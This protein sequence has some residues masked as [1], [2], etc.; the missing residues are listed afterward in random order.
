ML[1]E[2]T[3]TRETET[4]KG[5]PKQ[6]CERYIYDAMLVSECEVKCLEEYPECEVIGVNRS[7]I[8]EIVNENERDGAYYKGKITET[9]TN[10]NGDES[11]HSYQILCNAKD[12]QSA[13]K[14]FLEYLK[15][16]LE[17]ATLDS[18]TK[19]KIVDIL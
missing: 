17:D 8:M 16:T 13:T 3:L 2:I 18:V 10:D 6:V 4:A 14:I 19:T 1:Y 5:L 11:S 9:T 7:K 15:G 12:L